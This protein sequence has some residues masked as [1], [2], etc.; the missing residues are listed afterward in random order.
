MSL[1]LGIDAGGSHTTA[2]LADESLR[3]L[4]RVDGPA[5]AMRPGGAAISA[6]IIGET[7]RRAAEQA[8]VPLPADRM[9][10]GAAGAGRATEQKDL[11]EALLALGIARSVRVLG[12]G[13]A[14]LWSA[15]GNAPGML[16]SAGTGSIG[17]ARDAT[18]ALHR[19]GGYGW[20]MGDEGGGYWL[21]RR[22]LAAAGATRDGRS[23]G[24]TLGARLLSALGLRDFD[25]IVRWAATATPAQI[26][27]LAPHVLNAAVEGEMVAREALEEGATA[28]ADLARALVGHFPTGAPTS[29]ALGGGLLREGSPLRAA[30]RQAL[31]DV[32]VTLVPTAVDPAAGALRLAAEGS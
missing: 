4:A 24:S 7:A 25:D 14:A 11:R 13:E 17:Y 2:L 31:R 6:A 10:V 5:S 28:L 15:F 30:L 20:Q 3:I 19:V 9:A 29:L 16:L 22:G 21:G 27:G 18:G 32:P 12:D 1:Y 23:E 26:A 8:G